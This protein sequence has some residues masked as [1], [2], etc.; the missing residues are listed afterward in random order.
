MKRAD[1]HSKI[2]K[3]TLAASL[4]LVTIIAAGCGG[5]GGGQPQ[6]VP[7]NGAVPATPAVNQE[8]AKMD[9]CAEVDGWDT[10]CRFVGMQF[11]ELNQEEI[12]PLTEKFG[13]RRRGRT[14]DEVGD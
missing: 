2:K 10:D 1:K 12:I 8:R 11:A 9:L 14:Q 5:G 13:R 4:L 7:G 6:A 3:A